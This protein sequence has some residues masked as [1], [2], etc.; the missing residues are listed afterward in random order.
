MF[1]EQKEACYVQI[2]MIWRGRDARKSRGRDARKRSPRNIRKVYFMWTGLVHFLENI[3]KNP[4][5]DHFDTL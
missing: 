2:M 1:K 4:I 3:T 5:T